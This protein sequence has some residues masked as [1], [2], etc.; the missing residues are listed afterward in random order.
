MPARVRF[1]TMFGAVVLVLAGCGMSKLSPP[2]D[3]ATPDVVLGVYLDALVRGDCTAGKVLG[4]SSFG[5]SN[6]ELCGHTRVSAFS[7]D[8][9]PARP[10][11]TQVVFA[12]T[13][14]TSGTADGSI[15]AGPITWFYTLMLQ[16]SGSWRLAGGGGGP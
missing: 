15:H 3:S 9:R 6:G 13:L 8:G 12:T 7:V 5:F 2:P 14:V 10:N 4:T 16:P 1:G 11:P